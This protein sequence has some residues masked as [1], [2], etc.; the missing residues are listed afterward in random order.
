MHMIIKYFSLVFFFINVISCT[1]K[2]VLS[3]KDEALKASNDYC[4]CVKENIFKFN[5]SEELYV[6]CNKKIISKYRLYK[7]RIQSDSLEKEIKNNLELTDSINTFMKYF[8]LAADSCTH[9]PVSKYP[10]KF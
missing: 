1:N 6:F 3:I 8:I 4:D 2:K 10:H 9:L 7:L 5:Y